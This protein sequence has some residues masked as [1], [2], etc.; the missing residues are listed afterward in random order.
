MK[1][2][3]KQGGT[4]LLGVR[5]VSDRIAQMVVKMVLG[6]KV[7]SYFCDGLYDYQPNKSS[8]DAVAITRQR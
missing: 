3:N 5:I 2:P 4:R 7:E 8:I 6:S 1:T